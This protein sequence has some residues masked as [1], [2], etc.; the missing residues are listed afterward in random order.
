MLGRVHAEHSSEVRCLTDGGTSACPEAWEMRHLYLVQAQP[1]RR[2]GAETNLEATDSRTI[3][4]MDTEVWFVP[5]ID[6][7]DRRGQL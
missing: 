4:Y 6:T 5:Y 7:Y 1:R 2:G 3:I